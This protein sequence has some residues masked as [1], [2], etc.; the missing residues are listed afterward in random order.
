MKPIAIR[1][2]MIISLLVSLQTSAS[3]LVTMS[4][5]SM[6]SASTDHASA[7]PH[8][9][10]MPAKSASKHSS[11][12]CSTNCCMSFLSVASSNIVPVIKPVQDYQ[13]TTVLPPSRI[14][15]I[16]YRPPIFS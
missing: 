7:M 12:R 6:N 16:N 5:S 10:D 2:F 3:M 4:Y 8:C 14:A 13:E 9:A 15:R 1:F 11:E